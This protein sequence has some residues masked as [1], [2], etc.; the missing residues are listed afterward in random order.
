MILRKNNQHLVYYL[1]QSDYTTSIS[2]LA[3]SLKDMALRVEALALDFGFNY[4]AAYITI[5]WA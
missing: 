5:T 3:I 2:A 1:R 4:I